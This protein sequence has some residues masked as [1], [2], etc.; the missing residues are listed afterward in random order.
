M[1]DD[2]QAKPRPAL[3]PGA[4]FID[5]IKS[6]EYTVDGLRSNSGPV[7]LHAHFHLTVLNFVRADNDAALGTAIFDRVVDKVAKDLFQAP[8]VHSHAQIS[9]I[10]LKRN[11]LG[12][13]A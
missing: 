1:F 8:R 5:T 11:A 10:T 6:L 4:R 12:N 2:G 3:F 9:R 13:C 7:V